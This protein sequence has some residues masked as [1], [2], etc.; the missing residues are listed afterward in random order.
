MFEYKF[1]IKAKFEIL[2]TDKQR[3]KRHCIHSYCL[4]LH[5]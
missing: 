2:G 5:I 1:E 3:L 4:Y